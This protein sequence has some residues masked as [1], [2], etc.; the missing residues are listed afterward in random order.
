MDE[1]DDLDKR[2]KRAAYR[3]EV[4]HAELVRAL[5]RRID[6][7]Q[8]K[9]DS[10]EAENSKLAPEVAQLRQA[11]KTFQLQATVSTTA[12][13]I[14]GALISGYA[15]AD[16]EFWQNFILGSGW[17][18]LAV[19]LVLIPLFASFGWPRAPSRHERIREEDE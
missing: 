4:A 11:K 9:L 1:I 16:S 6:K 12:I 8:E 3:A 18:L 19:G 2:A 7:I 10:S 5:E 15:A 14:G 13:T 17:S